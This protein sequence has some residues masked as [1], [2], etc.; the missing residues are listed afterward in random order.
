MRY[1]ECSI[2]DKIVE[3]RKPLTAYRCNPQFGRRFSSQERT[4]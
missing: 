3:G 4:N 2:D 1:T